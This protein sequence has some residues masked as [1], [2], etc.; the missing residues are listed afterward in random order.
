MDV[1]IQHVTLGTIFSNPIMREDIYIEAR[2][3][4]FGAGTMTPAS[5]AA[6]DVVAS[7]VG[8]HL[9]LDSERC[10]W[11]TERKTPDFHVETDANGTTTGMRISR[12]YLPSRKSTTL[13]TATSRPFALHR[14]AVCLLSRIA[15]A[16]SLQEPVLLIGETGTGKTSVIT[17]LAHVLR[18]PL[19]SLNL[20]NQTESSDLIGGLKPVDARM[21]GSLLQERFSELFGATFSRKKNEKFETSIRKAVNEG[22][23]K[24]VVGLWKES[25]RLAQERFT[26]KKQE[27]QDVVRYVPLFLCSFLRLIGFPTAPT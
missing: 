7:I 19:I 3:V 26:A 11:L 9:G 10:H 17:H 18:R 23:W 25:V 27:N 1:D 16:V 24:R 5:K 21:P 20:S 2:D 4:F 15:T 8:E 6:M 14:P 22:K 12:T 13:F